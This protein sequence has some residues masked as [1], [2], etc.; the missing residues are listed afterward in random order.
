MTFVE[1]IQVEHEC[2]RLITAY[3]LLI[4]V[5]DYERFLDLFTDD[6]DWFRPFGQPPMKGKAQFREYLDSRDK[7]ILLRHVPSNIQVD[8]VDERNATGISYVTAYRCPNYKN[9]VAPMEGPFI[10]CE[11]R[12]RFA[13]TPNGWRI[14]WRNTVV[15]FQK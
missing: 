12:D 13:K 9:G 6:A 10:M 8:V 1:R 14:S 3:C 4:D 15:I 7:S 11:Y 5:N 2:A